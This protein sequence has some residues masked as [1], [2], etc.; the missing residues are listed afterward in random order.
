MYI[1]LESDACSVRSFQPEL[2]P[3]LLQTERYATSIHFSARHL[4]PVSGVDKQVAARMQ[5]QDRL[6]AAPPLEYWAVIGE[7]AVR[8]L[9]SGP[10]AMRDQLQHI[11][12]L[13]ELPNVK[14]QILPYEA[15][16]HPAMSGPITLLSFPD[17]ITHDVAYLEG[18]HVLEDV[19]AVYQLGMV[20]D[21]LRA[22]ALSPRDSARFL[23]S[24][25]DD[26]ERLSR[27]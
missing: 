20:Y 26:L 12:K 16:A 21:D 14:V 8:R 18:G 15:G 11:L 3:G 7:A 2:I 22:A 27:E 23:E 4:A 24:V 5:R 10:I 25:I 17:G 9:V 13:M 6:T 1:S 19:A